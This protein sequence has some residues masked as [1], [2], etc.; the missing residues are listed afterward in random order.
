MSGFKVNTPS[1]VPSDQ[2][3]NLWDLSDPVA[4]QQSLNK[5]RAGM[6]AGTKNNITNQWNKPWYS[7]LWDNTTQYMADHPIE[8][9]QGI[10]NTA[11]SLWSG[12]QNWR[13]SRDML[14]LTRDELAFKKE[15]YEANNKR[16][17]E[18]WDLQKR[19]LRSSSL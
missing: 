9:M 6:L 17:Q 16:A 2:S 4:R 5:A 7:N 1:Y 3:I 10:F 15:Q 18:A 8:T 13:N 11:G 14:D 12:Y 19:Q